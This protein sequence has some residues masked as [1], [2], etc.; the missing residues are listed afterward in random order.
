HPQPALRSPVVPCRAEVRMRVAKLS[1]VLLCL[2]AVMTGCAPEAERTVHDLYVYGSMNQ[3]YTYFYGGPGTLSYQGADVELTEA[4]ASDDRRAVDF[5]VPGTLLVAGTPFLRAPTPPLTS[6][7]SIVS[8]IPQTTDMQ[9]ELA[10][11]VGEVVYFDGNSYLTLV[12]AGE[13]GVVQR[14][15]P[16]P[17]FNR[18]RGVG[19]LTNAEADE[20]ADVLER[21]GP[22]VLTVLT[23]ES[24]PVR[25]VDGLAEQLTTGVY[26]Q[27]EI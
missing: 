14:V 21:S 2:A 20:L 4:R 1:A 7:P 5:A 23:T 25:A 8:R 22:F 9:L 24:L 18:L 11:T 27:P 19:M 12:Q 16:R 6:A 10:Q 3:R 15:I 13:A 17:R 26:V